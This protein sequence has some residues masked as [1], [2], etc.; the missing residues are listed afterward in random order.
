LILHL[1]VEGGIM[2]TAHDSQ[3]SSSNSPSDAA[4]WC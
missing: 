3:A 2:L 4:P 1:G